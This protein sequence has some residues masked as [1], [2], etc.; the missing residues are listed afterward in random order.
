MSRVSV[1][2]LMRRALVT[3]EDNMEA[4]LTAHSGR[5]AYEEDGVTWYDA[6]PGERIAVRL[7]SCDTRS[8]VNE[9]I[10]TRAWDLVPELRAR[11]EEIHTLGRTPAS[12]FER[13]EAAGL[14]K[15]STPRSYGSIEVNMKT[16]K[17]PIAELRW[18]DI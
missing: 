9:T 16:L 15:L 4:A 2:Y 10:V 1:C 14:L 8:G 18:S 13:V 11:S 3:Q 7:S 17:R 6:A 5:S 12:L